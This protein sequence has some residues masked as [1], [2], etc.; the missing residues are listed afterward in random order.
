M[1]K[2]TLII[3]FIIFMT[4]VF[5]QKQIIPLGEWKFIEYAQSDDLIFQDFSDCFWCQLGDERSFTLSASNLIAELN[6]ETISY[7]YDIKNNQLILSKEQTI[8][9]TTKAKG[10]EVQTSVGQT[11]F[12]FNR[13]G[14]KLFLK[15]SNT[16]ENKPY[17]FLLSK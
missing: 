12:D 16:Q 1:K 11:I 7:N 14:K 5:S 4:N 15:E 6:G 2:I 8:Q 10:T 13:K 17:T 3:P 9:V